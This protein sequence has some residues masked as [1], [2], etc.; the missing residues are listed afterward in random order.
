MLF[1]AP[2]NDDEALFGAYIIQTYK[3]KVIV[4]TDSHIQHERGDKNCSAA[5]RIGESQR[6]CDI[7]G[8]PVEFWHVP[9]NSTD[10]ELREAVA[11]ALR[12]YS[13]DVVVFAPAV[14]EGG[15]WQHNLIGSVAKEIFPNVV[16]YYTYTRSRDWPDGPVPVVATNEMR[17]KKL[18]ALQCYKSQWQNVCRM[19]FET[20]HKD[21]FIDAEKVDDLSVL[22]AAS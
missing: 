3:P 1:L 2:H 14:E 4:V 11:T 17:A 10:V 22:R 7:L 18:A 20:P 9:D 15:N 13:S 16:S 19:Y 5:E 12:E 21:E 6:A 8:A